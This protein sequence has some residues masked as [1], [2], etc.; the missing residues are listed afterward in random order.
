MLREVIDNC[1]DDR[2]K[3]NLLIAEIERDEYFETTSL[4]DE[5]RR[6]ENDTFSSQKGDS[7]D[8]ID[9]NMGLHYLLQHGISALKQKSV[10]SGN[11]SGATENL[12]SALTS[13]EQFF[14]HLLSDLSTILH[15][16]KYSLVGNLISFGYFI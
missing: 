1:S 8:V 3:G 6:K 13:R 9:K 15:S 7:R 5:S 4:G 10:S 12:N 14:I 16:P 11:S 2:K